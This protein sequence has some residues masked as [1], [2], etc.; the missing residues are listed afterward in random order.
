MQGIPA[1]GNVHRS[2]LSS[3]ASATDPPAAGTPAPL[4]GLVASQL[5]S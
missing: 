2:P 5:R 3:R 4:R 1:L